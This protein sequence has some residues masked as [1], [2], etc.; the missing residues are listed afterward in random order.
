MKIEIP[1]FDKVETG[2]E[3]LPPNT[4]EV[5]VTRCEP[6]K[7]KEKGTPYISWELTVQGPTHVGRKVFENTFYA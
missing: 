5:I 6:R 2:F 1:D 7:G 4:Y 3:P